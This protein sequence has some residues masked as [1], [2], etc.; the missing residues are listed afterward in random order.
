MNIDILLSGFGGQGLMSVG[1]II[2]RAVIKDGKNT[3]WFPSY[4]AEVRGGTAHSFVRISDSI[5]ASPLMKPPDIAVFLNQPSLDK[6]E[7][8]IKSGGLLICNSDVLQ[9]EPVCDG[10]EI[11]KAPL[12]SIALECDNIKVANTVA[13]GVLTAARPR[14][15]KRQIVIDVLKE[16]FKRQDLVSQN[17]KAFYKGEK[18]VNR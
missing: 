15:L 7:K 17:I 5:I 14:I 1:K 8:Q 16:T 9:R 18:V 3:T 10:V 6:F 2:A 4:G 13:L 11:I 12:N